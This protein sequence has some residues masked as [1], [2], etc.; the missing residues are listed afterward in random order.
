MK[1]VI[2][3]SGLPGCGKSTWAK[4]Q[5]GIDRLKKAVAELTKQ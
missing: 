5:L 3:T 1:D 4:S 2:I